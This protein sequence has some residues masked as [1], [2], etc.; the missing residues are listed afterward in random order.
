M[1]AAG[2]ATATSPSR[3]D[4][5]GARE[6]PGSRSSEPTVESS[7]LFQMTRR[8]QHLCSRESTKAKSAR[9]CDI[10]LCS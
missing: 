6:G 9:F 7:R 5:H 8:R 3:S 4:E 10:L 1:S 2:E